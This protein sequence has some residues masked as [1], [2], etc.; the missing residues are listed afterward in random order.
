MWHAYVDTAAACRCSDCVLDD[1]LI[2]TL[3]YAPSFANGSL[4]L[5]GTLTAA[6]S[7]TDL[8]DRNPPFALGF[9]TLTY[10]FDA[11]NSNPLGRFMAVELRK[12]W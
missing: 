12:Q 5:Q 1:G 7:V 10:G 9:G 8:L 4:L 3:R 11:A 2:S 6:L